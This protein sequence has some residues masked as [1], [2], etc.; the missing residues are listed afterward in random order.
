MDKITIRNDFHGSETR[1][2]PNEGYLSPRQVRRIRRDLC[3]IPECTCGGVLSER[4]PQDFEIE[5]LSDGGVGVF[6]LGRNCYLNHIDCIIK[7]G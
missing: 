1:A 6:S 4:G 2:V 3:G 7:E 5:A